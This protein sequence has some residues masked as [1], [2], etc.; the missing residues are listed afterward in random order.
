MPDFKDSKAKGSLL[1]RPWHNGKKLQN[2]SEPEL[3][4]EIFYYRTMI[5]NEKA[6][7]A[8]IQLKIPEKSR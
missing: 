7:L 4:F 8:L 3:K 5:F 2:L 1:C 6:F